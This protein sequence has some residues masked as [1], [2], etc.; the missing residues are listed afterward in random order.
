MYA[1]SNSN[2]VEQL[3]SLTAQISHLTRVTVV[4]HKWV[5]IDVYIDIASSKTGSSRKKFARM[6]KDC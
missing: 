3:Q 6:L 1:R 5:L 2:I 4:N